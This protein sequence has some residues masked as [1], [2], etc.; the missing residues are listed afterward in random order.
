MKRFFFILI[1]LLL[2]SSKCDTNNEQ[3]SYLFQETYSQFQEDKI[4]NDVDSLMV[5][6][7][8]K[9][10]PLKNWMT[11]RLVKENGY[12]EQKMVSIYNN[13]ITISFIYNKY[14][15]IDSTYY[16]LKVRKIINNK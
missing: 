11:N 3:S 7:K 14:N 13:S 16:Q 5:I 8:I 1:L 9:N 4:I 2:C 12:I 15:N 6:Y 10:I